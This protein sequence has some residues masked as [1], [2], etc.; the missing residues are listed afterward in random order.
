MPQASSRKTFS[1]LV[2]SKSLTSFSKKRQISWNGPSWD[3]LSIIEGILGLTSLDSVAM[4]LSY[5]HLVPFSSFSFRDGV[6][7]GGA[8]DS[9][10]TVLSDPPRRSLKQYRLPQSLLF[11][12]TWEILG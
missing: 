10:E 2:V 12:G 8:Q 9:R 11:R 6:L 7:G 3:D 1:T 5:K 4:L